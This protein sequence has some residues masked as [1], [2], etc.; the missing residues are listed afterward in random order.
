MALL[1]QFRTQCLQSR[2]WLEDQNYHYLLQRQQPSRVI[3]FDRKQ[4]KSLAVNP[5]LMRG[6]TKRI[7][8]LM[9]E[10]RRLEHQVVTSILVG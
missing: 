6:L 8:D 10:I 9:R 2:K 4:L 5:I 1:N 3:N 7:R